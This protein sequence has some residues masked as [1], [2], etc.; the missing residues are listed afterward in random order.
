MILNITVHNRCINLVFTEKPLATESRKSFDT[1]I[2]DFFPFIGSGDNVVTLFH[3]EHTDY[4]AVKGTPGTYYSLPILEKSHLTSFLCAVRFK[5]D[6]FGAADVVALSRF[7]KV[8]SAY[9][10]E[11]VREHKFFDTHIGLILNL[12][13]LS[14]QPNE[15]FKIHSLNTAKYSRKIAERMSDDMD[16]VDAVT[17]AALLHDI[18]ILLIDPELF[19]R[20][21]P[22][23]PLDYQNIKR[24]T[25][26][27]MEYL[28]QLRLHDEIKSMIR[29]HHERYDGSGC[30][31]GLK[32]HDIPLGSRII[33]VAETFEAMTGSFGYK[34]PVNPRDALEKSNPSRECS[35]IPK[36]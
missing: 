36:W 21:S 10:S 24:H 15:S 3:S 31:D 35:S 29:S 33:A 19:E 12:L 4:E 18:G 17:V 22:L 14:K 26:I 30:P 9:L 23:N 16:T 7:A 20:N 34:K 8:L 27:C 25:E 28:N 5:S 11:I 13:E 32:G 2:A 6:Y 1:Y